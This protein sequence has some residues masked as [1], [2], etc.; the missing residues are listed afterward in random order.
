[1]E[2]L[3]DY[4]QLHFSL[5]LSQIIISA[6]ILALGAIWGRFKMAAIISLSMVGYWSYTANQAALGQ[7]VA[8][9]MPM[10]I[11]T[12]SLALIMGFLLLYVWHSPSS[13]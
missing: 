1:M 7:L 2:A 6:G 3:Q 5:A 10:V 12:G 11:L 13:R 8:A 4:S 9:N